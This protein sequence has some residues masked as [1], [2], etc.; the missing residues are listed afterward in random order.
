[1]L[2]DS[3]GPWNEPA[4]RTLAGGVVHRA[5][6]DSRAASPPSTCSSRNARTD[7]RS[8]RS[9]TAS[10][11]PHA[12]S[13]SF[14][15][16]SRR[17]STSHAAQLM[18]R[19]RCCTCRTSRGSF[20]SFATTDLAKKFARRFV[21]GETLDEAV[22]AV[23]AL[24]AKG[25][26]ASL[27]LL[28]E[29]V[30]N[31]REA[32]AAARS[33]SR[34]STGSPE[35]AERERVAQAHGDGS[36]HLRG[37]VR[38]DHARRARRARGSTTAFVRLDMEGSAYTERTLR[39]F[40]DRLYPSYKENVGIVLQSYLYRTCVRRGARAL[41][42]GAAC[43]C[44][45]ARTRS[46]RPWR[47]PKR[48]KSTRTTSSAC[49]SCCSNGQ[50]SGHRDARPGDHRRGQAL[51]DGAADR[52]LRF[53]FQML[54]GV[55]RDLQEQLVGRYAC[56]STCLRHAVVSVP[57]APARRASGERGVHHRQR[58]ARDVRRPEERDVARAVS[59]PR[60]LARATNTIGGYA[61]VHDRPAAFEGSD[62]FSYSVEIMAEPTGD[63]RRPWGAFFLFVQVGARRRADARR[64]LESDYLAGRDRGT[65]R[66]RRSARRRLDEVEALLDRLIAER[67]GASPTR[68]GGTR[69]ATRAATS[70]RDRPAADARASV[71]R[72]APAASGACAPT[73]AIRSRRRCA[74]G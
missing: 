52:P 32:R 51:C 26:T 44:A 68:A 61:A 22:A 43:A 2:K 12:D 3:D 47:F 37:A 40:E 38:L 73:T 33:T 54:Y 46:R 64:P 27:D 4:S 45:R 55:R 31:E 9:S 41:Q 34:S 36:R 58:H 72:A 63:A 18:F 20:A 74:G 6:G 10:S 59:S 56:A 13:R 1:M 21:A 39:L 8:G 23:R 66:A 69:C 62:G 11:P 30:T 17:R 65:T 57:D 35:E 60:S 42:L 25:I 49:T 67:R 48:R 16:P 53:E 14:E 7:S 50:L 28:G 29:S 5:R 71:A 70:T 24:N 19:P 15:S